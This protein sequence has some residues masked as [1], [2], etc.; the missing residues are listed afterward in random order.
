ERQKIYCVYSPSNF[1]QFFLAPQ[2]VGGGATSSAQQS[3]TPSP[4]SSRP[5]LT[6]AATPTSRSC[7]CR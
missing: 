3:T 6:T 5:T 1:F 4:L 7:S 2:T